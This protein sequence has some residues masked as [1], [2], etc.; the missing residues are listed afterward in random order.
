LIN[1]Y[2]KCG[3]LNDA[4]SIF[5]G[6]KSKDIITW[7]AMIS[8][9]GK[10]GNYNESINL[11]HQMQKEG[12]QP[13]SI[14]YICILSTCADSLTLNF[15]KE[16]HSQI[17]NSGI[18]MDITLQTALI[19]MYSKCG[20]LSDAISIFNGM[21]AKDIITWNTMVSVYGQNRN[22]SNAISIFNGMKSKDI[23]TWNAMISA[24]GQSGNYK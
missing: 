7:N 10:N 13:D 24:Y 17:I 2:S 18:E 8:A 3:S 11:F 16:I 19:N 14:T 5:K 4:I 20:S 21:K 6:M 22:L 12:I 23:I 9:Y 15:G 1:M